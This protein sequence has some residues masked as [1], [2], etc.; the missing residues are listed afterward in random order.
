ML[1]ASAKQAT[2]NGS[3]FG[4]KQSSHRGS[5]DNQEGVTAPPN[6]HRIK[7]LKPK[8][9]VGIPWRV[10]LALQQDGW[11]LR[12]DIVWEKPN[13]M[14][15]PVQDRPT[16]SHEY[17]FLLAKSSQYFYDAQAIAQYGGRLRR[18]A[19]SVWT[20]NTEPFAGAHF[21]TMPTALVE[22]CIRAGSALGDTVCD[23]FCGSGTVPLVA[24]ALGR[25]SVGLD[26]SS[27]YL[28]QEARERLGL[29]D[30]ARWEGQLQQV[31]E[32]LVDDLPL[33]RKELSQ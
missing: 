8:D 5:R 9:L 33:F 30:L 1:A 20:M 29:A 21:A 16:R 23:P 2:N 4:H 11:T 6:R 24:R 28:R 10:A 14:P 13:C 18:N 12:C 22:R 15:E 3:Y 32:T 26:L 31:P 19:R 27:V 17:L 7:T 25:H